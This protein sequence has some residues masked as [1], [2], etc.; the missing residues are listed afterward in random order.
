MKLVFHTWQ[1]A[2]KDILKDN[3]E[4]SYGSFHSGSIFDCEV[5]LTTREKSELRDALGA[6]FTPVFQVIAE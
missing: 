3:P 6:G 5:N 1:K 4:L 2:G